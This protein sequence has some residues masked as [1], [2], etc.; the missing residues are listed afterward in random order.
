MNQIINPVLCGFHPDPS[1]LRVE[2]DYYIAVSTFEW[3]PGVLIY[4]SRD[5]RHWRYITSALTRVSQ[6]DMRGIRSSEGVWAPCLSYC[7][8]RFYLIYTIVHQWGYDGPRDLHNY[9]VTSEDIT[10]SWSEPVYLNS[11]GFDPSMFHDEDGK[12]WLLNMR[13][14]HR[15]GHNSFS[16]ILLQEFDEK[17]N[18]LI[19][20][21][22]LIFKGTEL[23]LVEGPHLYKRNG[24]YYLMTAEGG[25]RFAHAVTLARSK[26]IE[27]PY[28]LHP[29]NPVLTSSGSPNAKLQKAGHGSLVETREGE[30]YMAHLCGRPLP[31][32]G[33]CILGRETAIQ[34]VVWKEDDWLYLEQGG[35]APIEKVQAPNLPLVV[36]EKLPEMDDFNRKEL[37]Y[38][39]QS[40]RVPLTEESMSL[41]ERPGYLR[42]KGRESLGSCYDQSLVARRQQ[43]F[44]YD[45][46]TAL[47]FQPDTFQQ[48]A[49]LV[50]LYDINNFFYCNVTWE[51]ELGKVLTVSACSKGRYTVL[52]I[53]PVALNEIERVYIKAEMRYDQLR[54]LYSLDGESW[55]QIGGYFDSSILSD[56]Y[57]EPV[58]FTGAFVGLCCQDLSGLRKPADFDYFK[59]KEW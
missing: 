27:G 4:H 24:Y 30:W 23:G 52:S 9:L 15:I 45:A 31:S 42:L 21:P 51:E 3:F 33:R 46:E 18:Q 41:S 39:Y 56:D 13:W 28:E 17:K 47:E 19:G 8:G 48:M 20:K 2:D 29:Q 36:W 58:Q 57:M 22:C 59:Y 32:R 53:S 44:S 14:D 25:T 10:G 5:M 54:F 1:I 12:H 37:G 43:A 11:S 26:D 6:L 38:P 7:D 34:K 49:G 16:G 35:R 40:L 55:N 50:V